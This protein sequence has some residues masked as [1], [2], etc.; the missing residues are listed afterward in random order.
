MARSAAVLHSHRRTPNA[1]QQHKHLLLQHWPACRPAA[2]LCVATV[3]LLA[4]LPCLHA[5]QVCL[6]PGVPPSGFPTLQTLP[7]TAKGQRYKACMIHIANVFESSN[8]TSFQ[9]IRLNA[10]VQSVSDIFDDQS[11]EQVGT[12]TVCICAAQGDS[13]CLCVCLCL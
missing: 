7:I 6:T 1:A 3:L 11:M 12:L 8:F 4:A 2:H 5:Q 13:L 10:T 9:D